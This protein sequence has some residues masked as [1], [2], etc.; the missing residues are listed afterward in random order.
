MT[1]WELMVV[2]NWY[3]I[4]E[5]YAFVAGPLARLYF[6]IYVIAVTVRPQPMLM[7]VF[8]LFLLEL[9]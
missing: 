3:I 2:N 8:V 7:R 9:R 6:M 5:A 1:L 4:M